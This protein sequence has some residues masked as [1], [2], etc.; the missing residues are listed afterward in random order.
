MC[1]SAV[2]QGLGTVWLRDVCYTQDELEKF[3]GTQLEIVSCVA[4]G[5][6]AEQPDM[7]PR[8]TIEELIAER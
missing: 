3:L 2:D 6:P 1:L 7:R 5:Y 8:K 4:V